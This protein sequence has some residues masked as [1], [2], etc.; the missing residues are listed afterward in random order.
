MKPLTAK[1]KK[2]LGWAT[3]LA[4][5]VIWFQ[6]IADEML[7]FC[8]SCST[9]DKVA[10]S[11]VESPQNTNGCSVAKWI[12]RE[13]AEKATQQLDARTPYRS[14]LKVWTIRLRR[15]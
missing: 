13:G 11:A 6:A 7:L 8:S 14:V 15:A 10:L 2:Q 1:T 12:A 4:Q 9:V 3:A 5:V